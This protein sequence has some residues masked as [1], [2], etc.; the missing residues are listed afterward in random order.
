MRAKRV[1]MRRPLQLLLLLRVELRVQMLPEQALE[2]PKLLLCLLLLQR[3]SRGLWALKPL[4]LRHHFSWHT[5]ST[6]RRGS[7]LWFWESCL[8]LVGLLHVLRYPE[9]DVSSAHGV[10][11]S[12]R[13]SGGGA[14]GTRRWR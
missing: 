11:Q 1:Q 4:I 9:Q 2:V 7:L 14:G 10:E 3:Y 13:F 6:A 5:R 8:R 12:G